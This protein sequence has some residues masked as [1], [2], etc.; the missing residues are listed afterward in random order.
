M[1]LDNGIVIR[2]LP[3]GKIK[4]IPNFL[5]IEVYGNGDVEIAYWRKCWGIRNDIITKLHLSDTD[6]SYKLDIEDIA[7]II[8]LL[9]KYFSQDY[10]EEN[11][12]SIWEFDEYFDNMLQNMLN[13][14]WLENYMIL[15][16]DIKVEFYDSY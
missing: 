7:A 6:Y 5:K 8:K 2:K 12:D 14:K 11:A 9:S 3:E 1:G 15:N 16:P 13:L 10:W 4:E